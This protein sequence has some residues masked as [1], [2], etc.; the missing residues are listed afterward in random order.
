MP[1]DPALVRA[2]GA[3]EEG[4]DAE[5]ERLVPVIDGA[6]VVVAEPEGPPETVGEGTRMESPD[7]PPLTEE[8]APRHGHRTLRISNVSLPVRR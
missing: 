8:P 6:D 1:G 3:A 5:A 2:S 4:E 7:L